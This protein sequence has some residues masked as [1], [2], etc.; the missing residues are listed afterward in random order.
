MPIFT[1]I[2][3]FRGKFRGKFNS[4]GKFVANFQAY[5]FVNQENNTHLTKFFSMIFSELLLFILNLIFL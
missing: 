4:R 3:Q 1:D 2:I 5:T